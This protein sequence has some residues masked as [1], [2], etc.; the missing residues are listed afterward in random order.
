MQRAIQAGAVLALVL[1]TGC[2]KFIKVPLTGALQFKTS[3]DP[4]Q[5][6]GA[7]QSNMWYMNLATQ[8]APYV[9][10]N[11]T[12]TNIAIPGSPLREWVAG[13]AYHASLITTLR[14]K[15]PA[16]MLWWQGETDAYEHVENT[17]AQRFTQFILDTRKESGIPD[18]I[19]IFVQ[20]GEPT[21]KPGWDV[22]QM[23]QAMVHL[24]GV[25]MVTSNDVQQDS[26]R[27]HYVTSGGYDVMGKRL[28]AEFNDV[29]GI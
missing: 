1:L 25:Y 18:L 21:G 8:F 15:R 17:Y 4:H 5:V 16:V 23:Q 13:G 7:G 22:M 6:V 28:A 29:M 9:H 20:L 19:V 12:T 10:T 14:T 24:P 27:V 2:E 26:D 11:V 3:A